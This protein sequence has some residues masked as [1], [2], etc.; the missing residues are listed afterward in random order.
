MKCSTGVQVLWYGT[1][2]TDGL[3]VQDC[4]AI[5]SN[6]KG[7]PGVDESFSAETLGLEILL[8]QIENHT[9]YGLNLG[10]GHSKRIQKCPFYC[11]QI[12][13]FKS[14]VTSGYWQLHI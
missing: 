1:L 5:P 3:G 7:Y 4:R 6:L 14:I 12:D 13:L 8:L 11:I 9:R 10:E 2:V